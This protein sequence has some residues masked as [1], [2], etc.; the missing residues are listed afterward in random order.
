MNILV[1]VT[2]FVS[3]LV[4]TITCIGVF[5][6]KSKKG[7]S[8]ITVLVINTVILLIATVLFYKFDVQTFHKQKDGVFSSLGISV[9]V[10]FIPVL[11][12]I[13]VYTLEFLRYQRKKV[14]Y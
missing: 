14:Y 4:S 5:K 12:L 1:L 11:T 10:F 9:F 2:L 6:R 8:V 7:L 3:L 13:N